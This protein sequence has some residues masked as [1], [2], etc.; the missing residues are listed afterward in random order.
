MNRWSRPRPAAVG[1]KAKRGMLKEGL[2][3]QRAGFFPELAEPRAERTAALG[4][5]D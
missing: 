3:R 4:A 2:T 5:Q 1:I